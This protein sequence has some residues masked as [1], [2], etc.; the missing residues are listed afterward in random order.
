[1]VPQ[2][3]PRVRADAQNLLDASISAQVPMNDS[4]AKANFSRFVRNLPD[5]RGPSFAFAVA[6]YPNL[7]HY[8]VP[9]EPRFWGASAG[10]EF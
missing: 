2:N 8:G 9:R 1:M 6:A 7:W 4:G 10:F 5:D 3:D